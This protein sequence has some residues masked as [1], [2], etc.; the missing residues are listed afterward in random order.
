M[1]GGSDPQNGRPRSLEG[2]GY[3]GGLWGYELRRCG[4]HPSLLLCDPLTGL[5]A[6]PSFETFLT[7]QLLAVVPEGV[8]LAIGDVDDLKA[9]VT[10]SRTVDPTMFGHLA[11]NDCM[12]QVG[13]VTL[14]WARAALS[15]CA[16]AVCGTFGGDE[17]IVAASGRPY[18][19]F[20]ASVRELANLIRALTP[21]SCSF[22][23]GS[24]ISTA[25]ALTDGGPAYRL[26]V[27]SVD[28]ALFDAKAALRARDLD[29]CGEVIDIGVVDLEPAGVRST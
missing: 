28:A 18:E 17:V 22:A 1:I 16:L 24:A 3:Q 26:L 5:V 4:G 10:E 29:P 6:Y 25:T 9:Y 15:G 11:G 27:S 23:V 13:A 8:H 12:R 2:F 21:R 14:R 20:L 19:D 7:E